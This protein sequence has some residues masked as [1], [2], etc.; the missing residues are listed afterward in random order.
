[1]R[2]MGWAR[3]SRFYGARG[4]L[5][6][7][8]RGGTGA[9]HLPGAR[10]P[11]ASRRGARRRAGAEACGGCSGT[12]ARPR[13]RGARLPREQ[14]GRR[15]V[16]YRRDAA[17]RDSPSGRSPTRYGKSRHADGDLGAPL[18][19]SRRPARQGRGDPGGVGSAG[20]PPGGRRGRTARPARD[21]EPR[22]SAGRKAPGRTGQGDIQ[23]ANRATRPLAEAV[24]RL[25]A[26]A[27]GDGEA[28]ALAEAVAEADDAGLGEAL[29]ETLDEG[30]GEALGEALGPV[31][32]GLVGSGVAAGVFWGFCRTESVGASKSGNS[33]ADISTATASTA[34]VHKGVRTSVR[35]TSILSAT[36]PCST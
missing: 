26:P 17:R 19:G 14:E 21:R 2:G 20:G 36:R 16:R 28:D 1:M 22:E 25:I 29:G 9:R 18:R 32:S 11:D 24:R 27:Q 5:L 33:R 15:R 4:R 7:G 23:P 30:I 13:E 6:H 10:A 34:T 35:G 3:V 12:V 8:P 31:V